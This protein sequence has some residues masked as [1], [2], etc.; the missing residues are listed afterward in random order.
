MIRRLSLLAA[1]LLFVMPVAAGSRMPD[2][3]DAWN[4]A[5]INWRDTRSGIYESAHSG[6]PVIMV[7]HATWC[8]FCKKYRQVF[9][10]PGVIDAAHDFVMILVDVDQ[11]KSTNGAFSPD[12]TY[13]PRTVFLDSQ[14]EILKK[15]H[16]ESDPEHPHS[17][18]VTDPAELRS[19]MTRA[20]E[21]LATGKSSGGSADGKI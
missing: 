14:G 12:G 1:L 9:K 7:F 3:A 16:G 21:D 6:K 15:Y 10:D 4:G 11:E 19:L 18:D 8:G 17:I 5:A 20:R 2:L 13:V